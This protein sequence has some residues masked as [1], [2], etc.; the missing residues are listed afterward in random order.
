MLALI[1]FF[2]YRPLHSYFSMRSALAQRGAEVS[3]LRVQHRTLERR[4]A[5]TMSDTALQRE[6]RR[7]GLVKPGERLFIVKG[8][9]AWLR[10]H[11]RHAPT[12]GVGG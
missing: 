12:M 8:I 3:S 1:A 2:Y 10:R 11:S 9:G 4:L 6:A 7:L 5:A